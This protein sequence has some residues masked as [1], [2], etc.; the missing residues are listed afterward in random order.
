[1]N[2]RAPERDTAAE[3][4]RARRWFWAFSFAGVALMLVLV[5]LFGRYG[6]Q[7]IADVDRATAEVCYLSGRREAERGGVDRAAWY[8]RQ[9]LQRRFRDEADRQACA[10]ALAALL[11]ANGRHAE[12]VDAYRELPREALAG[13]ENTAAYAETLEQ[14]G[15]LAEA[16]EWTRR[17]LAEAET[18]NDDAHRARAHTVLGRICLRTDRADEAQAQFDRATALGGSSGN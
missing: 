12:A 9:A 15:H 5:T 18:R 14:A 1:M 13:F 16:E 17:W 4:R 6:E 3:L 8:Y 11:A 7:L 2:E 10:L